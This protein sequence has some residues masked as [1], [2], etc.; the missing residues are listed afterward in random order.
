M[1]KKAG[2]G[3][4]LPASP[5]FACTLLLL[6]A[7]MLAYRTLERWSWVDCFYAASGVLTTVGIVKPPQHPLARFF[8]AALNV[9][10]MGV[11][12][13]WV[14]EISEGRRSWGRR[15]LSLKT[16]ALVYLLFLVPLLLVASL[17]LAHLEG[18]VFW[19]AVYFTLTCSTGLGM[20]DVEP[21]TAPARVLLPVY[22]FFVMGMTYQ[23]CAVFGVAIKDRM[24][25]HLGAK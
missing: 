18:W 2:P 15:A 8:T 14:A 5:A 6:G 16:D 3:S 20:G 4:L 22:L 7:G 24:A 13:L 25:Q 11:A 17:V 9:C 19:E 21:L 12:G 10:S 23:L 1:Q